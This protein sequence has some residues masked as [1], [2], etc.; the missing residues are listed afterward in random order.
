MKRVALGVLF[1]AA[2]A[3]FAVL[4]R[5]AP[6]WLMLAVALVSIFKHFSLGAIHDSARRL[7]Y[8]GLVA[9]VG[10]G[11]FVM[12]YPVMSDS[13]MRLW[14]LAIRYTLGALGCLFLLSGRSPGSTV[15]PAAAGLL[16]VASFDLEAAIHPYLGV[17]G[18]AGIL[19]L[20]PP[21][22]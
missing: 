5:T 18:V 12:V 22:K 1:G 10:F 7:L 3:S 2:A 9:T 11:W 21:T 13:A 6:A 17:A 19:Y 20:G 14:S 16:L 8:A 4:L 15:I